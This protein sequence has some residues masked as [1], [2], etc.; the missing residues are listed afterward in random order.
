MYNDKTLKS[1]AEA[2]KQV[3]EAE[4]SAKQKQI[5][6]IAEPKHKIDAG[7]L[8][9]LRAGKKPVK[10]S[11]DMG[12]VKDTRGAVL[13][14]HKV[15]GREKNVVN[16]PQVIKKHEEMGYK[17]SKSV[18][19]ETQV[20]EASHQAKTTMKHVKNPT[21][22]EK[23]AAK[24][25]KP[26]IKGYRDRIAMLHSAG[27][28]G[29]LKKEEASQ[30]EFNAE[31]KKAQA[32]SQGKEKADVAKPEVVAVKQESVEQVDEAVDMSDAKSVA[33]HLA[34]KAISLHG[35]SNPTRAAH[36]AKNAD[37]IEKTIDRVKRSSSPSSLAKAHTEVGSVSAAVRRMN[38][39]RKM[40]SAEKSA[41][42][43][44]QSGVV[45][46]L[47]K[48]LDQHKAAFR[49]AAAKFAAKNEEYEQ[50]NEAMVKG[51]GY[52][53]PE[54]ERKAPE[55][56]LSMTS[57]MP[58]HSDKAARFAAVQA[59]GK[60]VKGSAQSA[61][62]VEKGMKKEEVEQIDERTLSEPETAEKERLVKSMKKNLAGFK[63]RYGK[64]TGENVM[65]A[66]A[67]ARAKENK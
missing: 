63:Q 66:T 53:N 20:Q 61:K 15:S 25:I 17:V 36:H 19:E 3:M 33:G 39:A 16:D 34:K 60:L 22:G 6:K 11:D 42:K 28:E 2:V 38:V 30:E 52:D 44:L 65:Y 9:G 5:A 55:G 64:E 54:N 62:Q 46:H 12:P 18:K 40:S 48:H 58:G 47:E 14:V 56:K 26:G 8:A 27:A 37:A 43:S 49:N 51:K 10:E 24:D 41:H 29:R 1:V 13:M 32:K 7:D 50:V 21:A 45:K 67:T 31:I 59:K 35:I 57:L 23:A 4:L